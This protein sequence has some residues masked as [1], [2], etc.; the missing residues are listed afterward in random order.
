MLISRITEA[1]ETT[2]NCHEGF[3]PNYLRLNLL[4]RR[5]KFTPLVFQPKIWPKKLK[6]LTLLSAK[7]EKRLF[8]Y[9]D[10]MALC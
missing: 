10:G 6:F 3:D 5:G 7:S 4:F 8:A 9:Y 2:L 1:R